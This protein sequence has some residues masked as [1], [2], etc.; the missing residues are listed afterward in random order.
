MRNTF[1][2]SMIQLSDDKT[3]LLTGDLGY[4]VLDKFQNKY[5]ENYLNIGIAEQNMTGVAAGLAMEGFKVLTYSIANFNTLRCIEQIR[6]DVCYNNLDV[7]VVSVGGGF[8]YGSAGYSHHA[9]QDIAILGSMPN[10]TL[11]MP[12]DKQEM[13]F[14]MKYLF[15]SS[16]PKYLRVGKNSC[17]D[18][19]RE[20]NKIKNISKVF[21]GKKIAVIGIG[22]TLETAVKVHDICILKGISM[23]VYSIPVYNNNLNEELLSEFKQYEKIYVIEE[24]ISELGF[25]SILHFILQDTQVKVYICGVHKN[26]CS[27]VGNQTQLCKKHGIDEISI[28]QKIINNN[29][30]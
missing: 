13:S 14:C 25:G 2:N 27:Y 4:S 20:E 17:D 7:T 21:S 10:I 15:N 30:E 12:N 16:G 29:I 3:F 6:N 23:S 18:I 1:I 26:E 28:S 5:P 9:V 11:L 22:G 24:H 8:V 19:P